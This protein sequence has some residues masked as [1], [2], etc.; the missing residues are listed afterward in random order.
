MFIETHYPGRHRRRVGPARPWARV[1]TISHRFSAFSGEGVPPGVSAR[2][3]TPVSEEEAGRG[4]CTLAKPHNQ[5]SSQSSD[6]SHLVSVQGPPDSPHP[7]QLPVSLPAMSQT[8][9]PA[10]GHCCTASRVLGLCKVKG[11]TAL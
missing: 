5:W 3:A 1:K 4:N 10:T 9:P 11:L 2:I 7:P 8:S 6:L